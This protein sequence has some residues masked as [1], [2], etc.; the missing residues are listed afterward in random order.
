MFKSLNFVCKLY[1]TTICKDRHTEIC[2]L[3]EY[4]SQIN[5]VD[6]NIIVSVTTSTTI[7]ARSVYCC[8]YAKLMVSVLQQ[9]PRVITNI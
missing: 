3:R 1:Y 2:Y 6:H 9:F 7:V 8:V 5:C 4:I